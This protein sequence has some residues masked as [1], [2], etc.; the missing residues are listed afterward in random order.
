MRIRNDV[1]FGERPV[2]SQTA[3]ILTTTVMASDDGRAAA[4]V[5]HGA[6]VSLGAVSRLNRPERASWILSRALSV[7]GLLGSVVPKEREQGESGDGPSCRVSL[8]RY[9]GNHVND[10]TREPGHPS[11]ASQRHALVL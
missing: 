4:G 7:K 11:G 8:F 6:R 2:F 1:T 10:C 3:G 5:H 9:G